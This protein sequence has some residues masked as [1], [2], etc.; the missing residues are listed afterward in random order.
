M[1]FDPVDVRAAAQQA[2]RGA[3][4]SVIRSVAQIVPPPR[5]P[6]EGGWLEI[7]RDALERAMMRV[8]GGQLPLTFEPV[9]PGPH[10][11][12]PSDLAAATVAISQAAEQLPALARYQFDPREVLATNDGVRHLVTILSSMAGDRNLVAALQPQAPPAAALSKP[13]EM[14]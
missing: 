3:Q 14:R 2:E 4:A 13:P 6:L 9:P 8:A 12:V 1:P 11:T 10:D 5:E 7:A